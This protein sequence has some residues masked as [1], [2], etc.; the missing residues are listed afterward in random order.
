MDDSVL[1]TL[2]QRNFRKRFHNFLRF[3]SWKPVIFSQENVTLATVG[4]RINHIEI[5]LDY[6]VSL[7][8]ACNQEK[9]FN[10]NLNTKGLTKIE[11]I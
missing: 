7:T 6:S 9:L 5:Y 3:A 2:G 8:K 11:L 10:H 4:K 1:K